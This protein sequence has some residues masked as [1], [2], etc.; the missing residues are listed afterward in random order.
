M[1]TILLV[2]V[3][4]STVALI[5]SIGMGATFS[6]ILYLWRRPG[7]L[8]RSLLAVY[9][10][11]ALAAFVIVTFWPLAPGVEAALLVLAVS[12]GAPLLP[13]KLERFGSSQYAFS[14][15]VVTSLLAIVATPIWVAFLA[16]DF[17]VSAEISPIRVVSAIGK[18]FVLP[19]AAGMAANALAPSLT[20]R[21][22]DRAIAIAG[23][24]LTIA[25]LAL[26][27]TH[28]RIL[29]EIKFNGMAAL[30]VLMLISVALGHVLGGPLPGDRTALAI[31]CAT[32]YIGIAIIVAATFNGPRNVVILAAYAIATALV[33]IPYLMWR[34][35][36]GRLGSAPR[37]ETNPVTRAKVGRSVS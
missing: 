6:D 31:A 37:D 30:L 36:K 15:V 20:A 14:L 34:R 2:L 13:R 18:G 17:G 19:L 25:S 16:W 11:V 27:I 9:V 3:K 33:S 24:A 29:L 26:L 7:L 28:W 1:T 4:I 10:L 32:R 21:F 12:A 35:H 22:A 8:L 23:V 5:L